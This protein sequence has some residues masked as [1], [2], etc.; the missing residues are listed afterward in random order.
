VL[1]LHDLARTI[2]DDADALDGGLA[3]TYLR[4]DR[5]LVSDAFSDLRAL[6]GWRA[7]ARLL[8][9]LVCPSRAYMREVYAPDSRAPLVALYVGRLVAALW[10]A[11]NPR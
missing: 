4:A 11:S 5:T 10:R 3:S 9:E 6:K 1:H 2:L 7:R 8:G